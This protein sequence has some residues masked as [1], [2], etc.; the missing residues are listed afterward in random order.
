MRRWL[1]AG[2]LASVLAASGCTEPGPTTSTS[3]TSTEPVA[4]SVALAPKP[5][6]RFD[7][8]DGGPDD[9]AEPDDIRLDGNRLILAPLVN[10]PFTV[11]D[12]TTGKTAWTLAEF[13]GRLGPGINTRQLSRAIS[14][15]GIVPVAFLA[16]CFVDVRTDACP[17]NGIAVDEAVGVAGLDLAT[18]KP[19]WFRRLAGGILE[20]KPGHYDSL[21]MAVDIAGVASGTVVATVR[22]D[23]GRERGDGK[24]AV[25]TYGLDA[26]SGKIR[27]QRDGFLAAEAL[28]SRALGV[29]VD[30]DTGPDSDLIV[31]GSTRLAAL[32]LATGKAA[33]EARLPEPARIVGRSDDVLVVQGRERGQVT[34]VETAT[35][36]VHDVG[37]PLAHIECPRQ[38]V[39]AA[40]ACSHSQRDSADYVLDFTD[41]AGPARSA[42][43]IRE[44]GVTAQAGSTVFVSQAPY[45]VL[46]RDNQPSYAARLDGTRIGEPWPGTVVA[47]SDAW[48]VLGWQ[49]QTGARLDAY[50]V[51]P[52]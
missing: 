5:G 9:G 51:Q 41:P 18:G 11:V 25:I 17:A 37:R 45:R 35:G 7:A 24:A 40:L 33:W 38:I 13:S 39:P 50:A 31:R 30:P 22:M 26:S 15:D 49:E 28:G 23:R 27:W 10:M 42:H 2:V 21:S 14:G 44:G 29:P 34:A 52:D 3:S 48:V 6:W 32:D 19:R 4:I 36:A 8:T 1:T 43:P 20:G 12:L 16:T 47:A 46:N